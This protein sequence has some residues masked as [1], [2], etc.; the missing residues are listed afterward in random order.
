MKKV[1][2]FMLAAVLSLSLYG[3]GGAVNNKNTSSGVVNNVPKQ[4]KNSSE[5]AAKI[6]EQN[7]NEFANEQKTIND[8]TF[9]VNT[10]DGNAATMKLKSFVILDNQNIAD[11][12]TI[13]LTLD[14]TNNSDEE[15]NFDTLFGPVGLFQDGVR[16]P[17]YSTEFDNNS[18][19]PI[20]NGETVEVICSYYIGSETSDIE[21]KVAD[22]TVSTLKLQ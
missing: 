19:T 8:A 7:K 3:C 9:E 14:C 20:K 22:E 4:Q 18:T 2:L 11:K 10:E 1:I 13:V 16:L 21:F 15:M 5:E 12:K 6:A 17:V